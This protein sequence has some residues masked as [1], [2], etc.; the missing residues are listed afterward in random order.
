MKGNYKI[1]LFDNIMSDRF[2]AGRQNQILEID[3]K[4]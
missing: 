1:W 3:K 2:E 4:A